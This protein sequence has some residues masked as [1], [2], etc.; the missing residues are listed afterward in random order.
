MD[1]KSVGNVISHFSPLLGKAISFN[2]PVASI[3]ISLISSAFDLDPKSTDTQTLINRIMNDKEAEAKLKKIEYDH[4]EIIESVE[5]KDRISARER[6]ESIVKLTGERD[7]LLEYIS[8]IVI[9]GYLVMCTLLLF[10]KIS[11]DNNQIIYMMFGQLT[12]G[13]IMVLS[14]YFGSTKIKNF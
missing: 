3:L 10:N 5:V 4:Q 9:A 1:L 6:E 14:Y 2:N 11:N 8:I 12:S 13:F 7:W